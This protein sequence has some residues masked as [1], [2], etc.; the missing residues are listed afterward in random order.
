MKT[1]KYILVAIAGLSLPSCYN[2]DIMPKNTTTEEVLFASDAGVRRYLAVAYHDMPVEDFNYYANRGYQRVGR[3]GN[4]WEGQKNSPASMSGEASGRGNTYEDHD[5]WTDG[6]GQ[7]NGVWYRIRH[8]N[9]M[10][11]SFPNYAS[12]F[13]VAHYNA[14]MAEAHF[15]RAFYYFA[16][17]RRYGGVPLMT[18]A[19][20]PKADMETIQLP[21]ST[22]YESWMQI[23][24]DLQYAMDNGADKGDPNFPAGRA[25][26]YAAAALMSRAMLYAGTIAKYT[27]YLSN[28]T[29]PA[30]DQGLQGMPGKAAEFFEKVIKAAEF[31]QKGGYTLHTNADKALGFAE[32]F[33]TQNNEDILI[34]QYD[35]AGIGGTMDA[36]QLYHSWDACTLP[37]GSGMSVQVGTCLHPAWNLIKLYEMPAITDANDHPV[38]FNSP[39]D[40]WDNPRMEARARGT[41]YFSGMTETGSG[42]VLDIQAGV[43]TSFPGTAT[44]A[45]PETSQSQNEYT[46]RYRIRS[47]DNKVNVWQ[48]VN[49]VNTRINGPFG[50]AQGAGDESYSI[51]GAFIRKYISSG[52][53][54]GLNESSQPWKVF[55]Y[56]EVLLNWA[57]AAYELGLETNNDARKDEAFTVLAELRT[58]AGAS[59]RTRIAAPK[60]LGMTSLEDGGLEYD[61]TVDENLQFI[62][63]ERAR[64][65][66]FENHRIYDLIRWRV[67]D[68]EFENG[69]AL[70]VMFPYYVMDEG[71]WIFLNDIDSQGRRVNFNRQRYYRQIPE[72]ALTRNKK[73]VRNAGY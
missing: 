28:L 23:Y 42:T 4:Q 53:I 54:R 27:P 5:Y 15:L 55:R 71:K 70:R 21:R 45:T 72:V 18:E 63:D 8:L 46:G 6:N 64:E 31:V 19:L 10:I 50:F 65:L 41:F 34:K 2:M 60:D 37:I 67:A 12:K 9:N 73:L 57:E 33:T 43:Y 25:N 24:K 7:A 62:R 3:G 66:A 48:V 17:V 1:L 14:I 35:K 30:V 47:G 61:F 56:G 40:L 44:E 11:A 58:R 59:A 20:D 39:N 49:G 51:T 26:R 13:S 38:R 32:V 29:G 52:G 36:A 16:L 68:Q 69:L 22:E